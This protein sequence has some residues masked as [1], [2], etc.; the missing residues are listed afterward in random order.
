MEVKRQLKKNEIKITIN[1]Y[2]NIIAKNT[3]TINRLRTSNASPEYIQNQREKLKLSIDEKN[4]KINILT[5]ELKEIDS[6]SLD[7]KILE[8][9]KKDQ[10]EV[11]KKTTETKRIND[12]KKDRKKKEKS[13][14]DFF[15]KSERDEN[16]RCKQKERDAK[17]GLKQFHRA[18]DT[19][20]PYM[21]KN[22]KEMPQNKGYVWRDV[23]FY[24]QLPRET[25]QPTIVF[26]KRGK[27]LLIIH[28]YT[29]TYRK[30]YEKHGQDK[31]ILV[32][33]EIKKQRINHNSLDNY[34]PKK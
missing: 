5:E 2:N 21:E 17:Y 19:M 1:E 9:Y 16:Y 4:A 10:E 31:R 24:G 18:I 29:E 28:E 6:G 15:W 11:N 27:N 8:E 23:Y 13:E 3:E 7:A 26:E 14:S 30:T 22:L 32:H 33:N 12:E 34:M 25:G 20:P